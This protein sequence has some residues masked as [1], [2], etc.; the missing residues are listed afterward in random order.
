ML[1][2]SNGVN[3]LC[4]ML[5]ALCGQGVNFPG[6]PGDFSGTGILMEDPLGASLLD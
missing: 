3:S 1:G 5:L 6:Q 2:G 4:A